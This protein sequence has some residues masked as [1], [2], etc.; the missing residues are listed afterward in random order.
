MVDWIFGSLLLMTSQFHSLY[1]KLAS[2]VHTYTHLKTVSECMAN[3]LNSQLAPDGMAGHCL[4]ILWTKTSKI[5]FSEKKDIPK[6]PQVNSCKHL[7]IRCSIG[8][9]VLFELCLPHF[10]P[11]QLRFVHYWNRNLSVNPVT[12]FWDCMYLKCISQKRLRVSGAII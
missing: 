2:A 1:L 3:A 9:E 4:K 11:F 6:T 12:Q 7:V 8:I 10:C 5:C